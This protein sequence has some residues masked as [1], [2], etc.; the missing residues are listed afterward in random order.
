MAQE[1]KLGHQVKELRVDADPKLP[2]IQ[3][4]KHFEPKRIAVHHQ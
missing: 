3:L 2:L 4:S 1:V